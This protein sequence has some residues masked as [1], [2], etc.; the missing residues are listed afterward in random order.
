MSAYAYTKD[1]TFELQLDNGKHTKCSSMAPT[2]MGTRVLPDWYWLC[3]HNVWTALPP[4]W[5]GVCTMVWLQDP[6]YVIPHNA[7]TLSHMSHKRS[8]RAS[9]TK[10]AGIVPQQYKLWSRVE[11]ICQSLFPWVG[12]GEVREE[13]EETRYRL[14]SF[15]N[16]SV[17]EGESVRKELT[18][19]RLMVMQNRLVLDLIT[20]ASGGVCVLISEQT[21][22]QTCCTF[23]PE[24]DADGQT[25]QQALNNMTQI[26]KE[27]QDRDVTDDGMF[28]WWESLM[29]GWKGLV[30]QLVMPLVMCIFAFCIG[31]MCIKACITK[32]V[33]STVNTAFVLETRSIHSTDSYSIQD[34][35]NDYEYDAD[36]NSTRFDSEY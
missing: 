2:Y 14:M 27:L 4:D 12:L 30:F 15:I 5:G 11:K 20:A 22:E 9:V 7:H 34:C 28:A 26:R 13:V 17:I 16:A 1:T 19:L 33:G 8:K 10:G 31:L 25:I 24:N 29:S 6:T 35:D 18:G 23:I 32:I 3:G 36:T 21:G